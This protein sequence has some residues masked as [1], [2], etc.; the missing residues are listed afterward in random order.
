VIKLHIS[1]QGRLSIG[2]DGMSETLVLTGGRYALFY[3]ACLDETYTFSAVD[4]QQ[5]VELIFDKAYFLHLVGTRMHLYERFCGNIQQG[6]T[7]VLQSEDF[8]VNPR[9]R[10]TL[11]ELFNAP[12]KGEVKSLYV[13]SKTIELLAQLASQYTPA[14]RAEA[15]SLPERDLTKLYE[16]RDLLLARLADPPSLMELCRLVGLNDFKLKKGF[17]EVFGQTVYGFV[18][19]TRLEQAR[20]Q[21]LDTDESIL[22][23]AL[24][25]GYGSLASF[26]AAFRKKFG[27]S[28]REMRRRA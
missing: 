18:L 5:F 15:S 28:P 25:N 10:Q 1:L 21:L 16:A 9:L 23:V 14:T 20:Q 7:A 19:E 11:T 4:P 26:S 6:E 3:S 2:L 12:Y 8:V 24:Q 22:G 17:K 27:V 13:Q